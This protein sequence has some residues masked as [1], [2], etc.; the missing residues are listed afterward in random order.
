MVPYGNYI[1]TGL[2]TASKAVDV[3]SPV[4]S[5]LTGNVPNRQFANVL[6]S[7]GGNTVNSQLSRR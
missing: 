3:V 7:S 4:I 1:N 6:G 5:N 2:Q